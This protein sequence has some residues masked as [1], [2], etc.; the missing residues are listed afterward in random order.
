MLG[1]L[2]VSQVV[3]RAAVCQGV[4]LGVPG[5]QFGRISGCFPGLDR[6][7]V[8][9]AL[10]LVLHAPWNQ[11]QDTLRHTNEETDKLTISVQPARLMFTDLG[12]Y[13]EPHEDGKGD[14]DGLRERPI[15]G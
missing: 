15:S 7:F 6:R 11:T 13:P 2:L 9:N 10:P 14:G 8:L 4:L 12:S 5:D 3:V 1:W